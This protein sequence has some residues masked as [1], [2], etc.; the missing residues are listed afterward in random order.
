[1]LSILKFAHAYYI[2][3]MKVNGGAKALLIAKYGDAIPR[4]ALLTAGVRA[5]QSRRD[6]N[7]CTRVTAL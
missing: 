6:A 2:I 3:Y 1:M 5:N 4:E 7:H